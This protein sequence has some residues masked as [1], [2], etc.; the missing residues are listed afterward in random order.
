MTEIAPDRVPR[1]PRGIMVRRDETRGGWVLLA[2]ERAVK[3]DD[4]GAAIL[5]AV[6]GARS[7]E[8]IADKL[9]ADFG[10]PRAQVAGDV[11]EFLGDL[12][13]RRML[14]FGP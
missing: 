4:I 12:A 6:D 5:A 13:N 2:P 9:A 1:L 7:L 11:A 8:A 3:L 14:E 10:A